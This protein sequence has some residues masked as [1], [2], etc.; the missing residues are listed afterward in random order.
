M[1]NNAEKARFAGMAQ[2]GVCSHAYIIDGAEGVGKYDFALFAAKVL[3]CTGRTKPCGVCP[4]CFKAANGSHPDLFVVGGEKPAGIADVREII[5]RASLKPNDGDRQVFIVDNA[6]KLRADAQNALLKI[7]EEPPETVAIFLLAESRSA[8]LPTVLSR[9]Q[10]VHLDGMTDAELFEKLLDEFPG[11]PRSEIESA[12]SVAAGNAGSAREYLSPESEK[13]RAEAEKI[14]SLAL[15]RKRYELFVA[16]V[17]PKFRRE[18]L[19]ALLD[20]LLAISANA[21]KQKY[22][23]AAADPPQCAVN[24][25]R[26]AIARVAAAAESCRMALESNANVTAAA[27]KL[28]IELSNATA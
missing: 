12:V 11:R 10:R 3:L 16:L 27:S 23:A 17:L 25:S 28:A 24:A 5:H 1:L 6:D 21:A 8:L 18:Q 19:Q 4:S 15:A 9:G 13:L 26:R 20:S 22:G 7:I 2:R 14:M